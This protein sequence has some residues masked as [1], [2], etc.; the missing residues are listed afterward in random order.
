M[1]RS[2][3]ARLVLSA[4]AVAALTACQKGGGQDA[5]APAAS[6]AAASAEV[7]PKLTP[8]VVNS[9][10]GTTLNIMSQGAPASFQ[11]TPATTIMIAHQ[12]TL[13]DIK[14]GS[15]LGTT[16]TPSP[17]GSGQST[18]VHVFPPGVKM[19]EGDRPMGPAPAGGAASRMTNGTVSATSGGGAR[20]T[21]GA[22][23]NVA[24]GSQGVQM[25]V[26]YQGGTRH[27][28][29]PPKTPIM[30]MASGTPALL[31][32]GTNVLVG[33]VP[34]SGGGETATFINIQP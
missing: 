16:N 11:L 21:N 26:V 18:E 12:G 23:G 31:K 27:I 1:H 24:T 2:M 17:D 28:V 15:F 8:G 3:M 4:C 7:Q 34:A 19:G 30:V 29:V 13:A 25:D 14:A 6:G 10:A 33:H 22:A 5:S 9:V 20:M 32:P